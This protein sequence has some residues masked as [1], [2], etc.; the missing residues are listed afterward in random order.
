M[1]EGLPTRFSLR[2]PL[3][4]A[5]KSVE[6]LFVSAGANWLASFN[7]L[8]H[9]SGS[10]QDALC[11]LATGGG[12]ASRTLYQNQGETV[13]EAK[14]PVVL[15]GITPVVTQQD[16]TDRVI[17]LEL[18]PL[19]RYLAELADPEVARRH[20]VELRLKTT[21]ALLAEIHGAMSDEDRQSIRAAMD[22]M[23]DENGLPA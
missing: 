3:R 21:R 10:S 20:A 13:F 2:V 1:Y 18:P 7:N 6:D 8:S 4:A 23:Y 22:A 5:P 9:L 14:R 11:S 15:N 17:H 19:E 16:L 12:Y